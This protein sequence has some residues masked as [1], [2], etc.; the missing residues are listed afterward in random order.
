MI[1]RHVE[2]VDLLRHFHALHQ[3]DYLAAVGSLFKFYDHSSGKIL[4]GILGR[5]RAKA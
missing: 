2:R 4:P 1:A 5:L 3:E